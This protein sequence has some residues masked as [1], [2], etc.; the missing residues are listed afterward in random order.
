MDTLR[1]GHADEVGAP[2]VCSMDAEYFLAALSTEQTRFL[3]AI[4][5]ARRLVDNAP[6]QLGRL[7]AVQARLTR[8][9][10]DAQRSIIRRRAETDA[11]VARIA[12]EAEAE[13]AEILT[14]ADEAAAEY[15]A[16]RTSATPTGASGP[17]AGALPAPDPSR[18]VVLPDLPMPAGRLP[19]PSPVLAAHVLGFS[20]PSLPSPR[21]MSSRTS[22]PTPGPS[23]GRAVAAH[24]DS[25][26]TMV[27]E[28]F[29]LG[30]P[31][32]SVAKQQLR[33]LLEEWWRGENDEDKA[34]IDDA[35]ARAAMRLHLARVEADEVVTSTRRRYGMPLPAPVPLAGPQVS[36]P[37]TNPLTVAGPELSGPKAS[38]LDEPA[39][40]FVAALDT[41]DLADL[42]TVLASLVESLGTETGHADASLPADLA[43][44][45]LPPDGSAAVGSSSQ[46]PATGVVAAS[47]D[48]GL[49][50]DTDSSTP[51][52]AAP[53]EAFDRFWTGYSHRRQGGDQSGLTREWAF[54]HVLFPAV[55]V[56]A[57]L[58]LVLAWFG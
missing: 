1:V 4:T 46:E 17:T 22:T 43:S 48:T 28:A 41:V 3:D 40:P 13:V 15:R 18:A 12:E 36:G 23:A 49:G 6:G 55:T 57:V 11:L 56:I 32:G 27:E 33:E 51:D 53:Q 24:A 29:E 14:A 37:A 42:D 21:A 50:A 16:L 58:A 31:D 8:E 45:A 34:T 54:V 2:S 20:V 19:A 7:A 38:V 25:L 35:N 39:H 30:D 52:A 9:F 26:A 44:L 10:L 47:G 5:E